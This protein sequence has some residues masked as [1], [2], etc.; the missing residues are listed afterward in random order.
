MNA[1]DR[2]AK[3]RRLGWAAMVA[4]VVALG[5]VCT[6]Q[7]MP[8]MDERADAGGAVEIPPLPVLCPT[9]LCADAADGR[10]YLRWNL[11]IEDE[12]VVGWR[13]TELAPEKRTV[14]ADT[15]DEP[16]FVVSGLANGTQYTFAVVGV[17]ANGSLTPPSSAVRVVPRPT[18]EARVEN[19]ERGK[20]LAIGR[21]N[22]VELLGNSV[23]VVF[24]D[25]QELVYDRCRPIGWKAADGTQLLYPLHFGNGLDVGEFDTRGLPEVFP[26]EAELIEDTRRHVPAR[27]DFAD[28]AHVQSG[29]RH[30]WLTKPMTLSL[31]R[32]N[33]DAPVKWFPPEVDGDRVTFRWWQPLMLMGYR[34]WNYVLVW[35]TWWPIERDL[36]GTTYRGLARMIEVQMPGACKAG[37]QVMVNNGFGPGGSREGVCCYSTGYHRP[38]REIVDFS[39]TQNRQI[40]FQ[41]GSPPRK[42]YQYH[43][44]HDSLQ[45]SPVIFY[46]WDTPEAR[47]SLMIASR[48]MYYHCTNGSSTYIEQGADGVWPNLAWDL[49]RPGA[50][51]HVDTVEYLYASEPDEPLPQR[52]VNAR[53]WA[54]SN[55]S[56]RMGVQDRLAVVCNQRPHGDVKRSGGPQA[57]ATKWIE[58]VE[59]WGV[60]ALDT[61]LDFWIALP[62]IADDRWRNDPEYA[63][64]ADIKQMC[65]MFREA[66]YEVGYWLRGELITTSIANGLSE[67]IPTA[68]TF[69][70][71]NWCD[72]PEAVELLEQRGLP[73]F[74][75]NPG[76]A[77]KQIDGSWP[78]DTPYQWI[79]MSL[80]GGWHDRIMWPSLKTAA[81]MG[82][83]CVLVDGGFGGMQGVDYSPMLAGKTT[84]AVPMQP[85]WWRFWRTMEHVGIRPYGECTMGWRGGNS[86][87]G[88]DGDEHYPWMF[89]MG[90]YLNK[91]ATPEFLHQL[92]QLYNGTAFREGDELL[93]ARRYAVKFNRQ[94]PRP[95]DWVELIDL[96][97]TDEIEITLQREEAPATS[98]ED[99]TDAEP[100]PTIK[101][102]AWTWSDA[103]WHYD[104][105]TSVVYPGYDKIDWEN[106]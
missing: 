46:D 48:S 53:F 14:T 83:S 37:Y 63:D 33:H 70:G 16:Q 61:P 90:W 29:T 102:R 100:E 91:P 39:G 57:Y 11:Q 30:P 25:G 96:R 106:E 78:V 55:V 59:G 98:V 99:K 81:A 84:E 50:R 101:L 93:A 44:N 13:V 19:I 41:A 32:R 1:S 95:P 75:E 85:F 47:G 34:A 68:G 97:Q 35:E 67:T 22:D 6:G 26:P 36:H 79:P 62:I 24:P 88:G 73:D 5:P 104:D 40:K 92:H 65:R 72:Y 45:A 9:G 15:L 17:L 66:G 89:Q 23:R 64:N 58:R 42:G 20:T 12:R 4:A 31:Q 105:G 69:W 28:Q 71:Y 94:N 87:V 7:E 60:D 103:V 18:G 49:A 3:C 54:F 10:A 21:F 38:G 82:F 8:T 74:R 2:T 77:R 86:C 52:F 51:T 43:P 76:W 56:R 80:A 27:A